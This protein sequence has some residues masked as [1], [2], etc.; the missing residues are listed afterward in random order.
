MVASSGVRG[1]VRDRLLSFVVV[2]GTGFLLLVSVVLSSLLA[3]LNRYLTPESLPGGVALWQGLHALVSFGIITLLFAMIYK[4]L[5]DAP[6]AWRDVW[7]G[8]LLAA[9]LFAVGKYLIGLY[10]GRSGVASAFGAAG[11]LV[12]ILVWVYYSSQI[13]LFGAEV[14]HAYAVTC[15]S[16]SEPAPQADSAPEAAH[17]HSRS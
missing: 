3:A 12:L 16:R 13:L 10:L 11:S 15:G 8:A 2:L 5:P 4:V 1:F 7:T 14:S 9:L 6:V 17:A